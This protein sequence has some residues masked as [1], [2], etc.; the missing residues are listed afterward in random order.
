[1][2]NT[3]ERTFGQLK[4]IKHTYRLNYVGYRT[5]TTRS[6][7]LIPIFTMGTSDIYTIHSLPADDFKKNENLGSRIF[8]INSIIL[9]TSGFNYLLLD[10][11]SL[12]CAL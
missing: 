12:I 7:I 4:Q 1:M 9:S 5:I 2:D 3:N 11:F 10:N 8:I 6:E